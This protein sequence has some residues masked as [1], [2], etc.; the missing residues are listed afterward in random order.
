MNM[1]NSMHRIARVSMPIRIAMAVAAALLLAAAALAAVNLFA[2]GSY[3]Q[4]TQSLSQNLKSA[5]DRNVDLNMLRLQQ[6]QTDAQF[7][8]AG[9]AKALL[10]PNIAN[11]IVTNT[12]I[13]ATFSDRIRQEINHQSSKSST[14]SG[15]GTQGSLGNGAAAN[16]KANGGLTQKQRQQV[17]Q[18]LKSNQAT[19][20]PN[21]N[22]TNAPTPTNGTVKP[23]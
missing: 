18:L 19:S 21:M 13:S 1:V 15:G 11:D 2:L 5:D 14:G 9:A 3:N 17:E 10:L 8:A 20:Q 16:S 23:W 22:T 7:D 4:A 6:A 12:R